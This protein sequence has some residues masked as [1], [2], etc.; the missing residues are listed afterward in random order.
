VTTPALLR[1][2][3]RSGR[4]RSDFQ[5]SCPVFVVTAE[6]EAGLGAAA[7]G[8]RKQIAFY[9]ST[10]AYRKVLELHGWG[11]LHEE[12]HRLSKQG[13]WDGMG[14]L[15]DDEILEEFAVVAPIEKVAAKIRD[16]CDG[17]IDRVMVGFPRAIPET[18]VSAI[19]KE[20]RGR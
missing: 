1:G 6:D 5:V 7:V 16:R 4:K 14:A 8:T 9:G 13:D 17:V 19:L 12:L 2:M 10:P 18:T 11:E 3:Q 20:L 15:I